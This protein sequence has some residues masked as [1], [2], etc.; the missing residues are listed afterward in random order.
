MDNVIRWLYMMSY[1]IAMDNV[2]V[3]A[4]DNV[5]RYGYG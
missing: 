2:T 5:T 4:M 3:T 1:V